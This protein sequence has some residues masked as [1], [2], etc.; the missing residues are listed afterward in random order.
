MGIPKQFWRF[1]A[2]GGV[3]AASNFG[4][5]FVFSRWVPYECAVVLAFLVG[6]TVAFLLMRGL[7]FNATGKPL[8][9]QA[10]F[11]LGVNVIALMQTLFVSIALDRWVLPSLGVTSHAEAL[12]HLVGVSVPTVTSY[13]GHRLATFK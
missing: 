6:M 10:A 12:A 8:G 13:F 7:V 2:A 3:A 5:R 4:S 1:L 11:F 9:P